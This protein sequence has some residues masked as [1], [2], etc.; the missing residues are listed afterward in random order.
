MA[1][2]KAI[3]SKVSKELW[4]E[5]KGYAHLERMTVTEFISEALQEKVDKAKKKIAREV[6]KGATK[7]AAQE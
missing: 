6:S 1:D 5:V 4:F 7:A 2:E 3:S